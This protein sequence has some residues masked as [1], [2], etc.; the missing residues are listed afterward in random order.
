M[1]VD[2]G[3]A[4]KLSQQQRS[5]ASG[6]KDGGG[7]S[8]APQILRRIYQPLKGPDLC[9]TDVVKCIVVTETGKIMSGGWVGRSREKGRWGALRC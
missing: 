6:L 5:V 2:M 4:R 3:E 8:D 1:Q 7:S 9:H